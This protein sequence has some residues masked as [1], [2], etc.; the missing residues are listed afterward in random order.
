MWNI[1]QE[2]ASNRSEHRP[3]RAARR[4]RLVD[5]GTFRSFQVIRFWPLGVL[6]QRRK[7]SRSARRDRASDA[8]M[9]FA[10]VQRQMNGA[11]EIV[12]DGAI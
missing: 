1:P 7:Q 3:G 12:F 8:H 10:P 9:L 4:I 6:R 5:S 2:V 11:T